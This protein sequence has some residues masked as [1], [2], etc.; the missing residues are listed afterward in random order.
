MQV[1]FPEFA[2]FAG[3]V[4]ATCGS[5]AGCGGNSSVPSTAGTS[6]A[7]C[8]PTQPGAA[9]CLTMISKTARGSVSGWAPADFQAR[10]KLPSLTKGKGQIVAIVDAYDNPS[11]A[12]DLASYRSNFGLGAAALFKYNQKGKQGSYPSPSATWGIQI[13]LDA[14]MVS[15]TCPN[16]TIYLIEANSESGSDLQTAEAEAVKLGAH[17]VSNSWVCYGSFSCVQKKYFETKGVEY[18]A[19]AADVGSHQL[20]APAVFDTVAAIG[21]TQLAKSG[22]QYSETIW[23]ASAGGC[24]KGIKKPKWQSSVPNSVCAYRLTNDAAAEGGCSPGVAE[25]D[26]YGY[27]GWIVTCGTSVASPLLAGVFGLAGNAAQQVGGQTFWLAKHHK[28]LYKIAG[29]CSG[30]THGQYTTCAGWGS[31]DGIGAF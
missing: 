31:P 12:G 30:Y 27:G 9:S 2:R 22:S 19:A 5:L 3:I 8:S 4:F 26:S 18:L 10:Y 7:A 16:C 24:A 14:E 29:Q 15:A 20:G 23:A 13:D 25:Y 6:N 17:I 1:R 11:V 28:H 21:A